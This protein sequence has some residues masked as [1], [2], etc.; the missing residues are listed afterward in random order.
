MYEDGDCEDLDEQEYEDAWFLFIK[1]QN[2]E[3]AIPLRENTDSDMMCSDMEGSVYNN[4]D[5][6]VTS[7]DEDRPHST[8]PSPSPKGHKRKRKAH[9]VNDTHSHFFMYSA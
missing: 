7:E 9:K 6:E 1:T 5:K 4:S 3:T 8:S 2:S